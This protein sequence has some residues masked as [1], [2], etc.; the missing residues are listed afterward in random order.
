MHYRM[1]FIFKKCTYQI[2][3]SSD[4]RTEKHPLSNAE[5]WVGLFLVLLIFKLT[6]F[7]CYLFFY[8]C[9]NI[10]QIKTHYF[11]EVM[12]TLSHLNTNKGK[13]QKKAGV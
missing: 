13:L 6:I 7:V 10:T 3:Y 2:L 8:L 9:K 5:K 4:E 11:L 12:K 1:F